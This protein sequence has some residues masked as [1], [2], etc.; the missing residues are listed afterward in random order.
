MESFTSSAFEVPL[1]PPSTIALL[2]T[3]LRK[4]GALLPSNPIATVSDELPFEESLKGTTPLVYTIS[5]ARAGRIIVRIH[6][7][8]PQMRAL[9]SELAAQTGHE[10]SLLQARAT[11]FNGGQRAEFAQRRAEIRPDGTSKDLPAELDDD[12]IGGDV[13]EASMMLLHHMVETW[14]GITT[15]ESKTLHFA[16]AQQEPSDRVSQ[17]VQQVKEAGSHTATHIGGRPAVRV[18]VDGAVRIATLS[19]EEMG[20]FESLLA[21]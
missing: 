2:T 14:F 9:L 11:Y 5:E 3:L 15:S 20:R 19:P 10:I 7:D 13:A 18:K 8:D 16:R 6:D 1:D 4:Q 12:E 21:E 17:L